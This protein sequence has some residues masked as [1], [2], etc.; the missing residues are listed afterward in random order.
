[1]GDIALEEIKDKIE[2][3]GDEQYRQGLVNGKRKRV[4]VHDVHV[5]YM[6]DD[7]VRLVNVDENGDEKI[8]AMFTIDPEHPRTYRADEELGT[9][10]SMAVKEAIA[11]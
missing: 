3:Y 5:I 9:G 10:Q 7:S 6:I 11:G 2:R 4:L 1:M 8:L